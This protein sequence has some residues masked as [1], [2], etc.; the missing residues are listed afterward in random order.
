MQAGQHALT[1]KMT[2]S[3]WCSYQVLLLPVLLATPV[4]CACLHT[5]SILCGNQCRT[6]PR[7]LPCLAGILWHLLATRLNCGG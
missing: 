5:R 1:M 6:P 3:S 4:C 7:L 2:R